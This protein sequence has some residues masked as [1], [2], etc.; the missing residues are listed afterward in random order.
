LDVILYKVTATEIKTFVVIVLH[1]M[2]KLLLCVLSALALAVAYEEPTRYYHSNYGIAE[3]AR[4]KQQELAL[5]FDGGR[6]AGGS[7]AAA[8][9]HPHLVCRKQYIRHLAQYK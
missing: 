2:M 8:G 1:N 9:A 5:D 7:Q 6:I 4:I 3:A